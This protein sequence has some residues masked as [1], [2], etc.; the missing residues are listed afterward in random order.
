MYRKIFIIGI[1]FS[2]NIDI[3][4]QAYILLFFSGFYFFYTFIKQPYLI[5]NLNIL[6]NAFN[7]L[8]VVII[9]IGNLYLEN[10]NEDFKIF[11]AIFII[12]LNIFVLT[13][14]VLSTFD[15]IFNNKRDFFKTKMPNFYIFYVSCFYSFRKVKI[16]W[17]IIKYA[18]KIAINYRQ[19]KESQ[20]EIL[21]EEGNKNDLKLKKSNKLKKAL[22]FFGEIM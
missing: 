2:E 9:L 11:L 13:L 19:F 21:D 18:K 14:W 16:R 7:L 5:K 17:N 22:K 12:L 3:K 10:F 1:S 6:E 20:T 4:L 8:A 15:I